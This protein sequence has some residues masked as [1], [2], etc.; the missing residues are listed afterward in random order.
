MHNIAITNG[1]IK[2]LHISVHFQKRGHCLNGLWK[3]YD[4]RHNLYKL[5]TLR[6]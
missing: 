5:S 1:G 4:D 3:Y 6:S 2:E